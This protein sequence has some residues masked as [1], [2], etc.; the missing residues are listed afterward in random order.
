[1]ND[2]WVQCRE[3]FEVPH[4]MDD[5][6]AI[7]GCDVGGGTYLRLNIHMNPQVEYFRR[8]LLLLLSSGP[9]RVEWWMALVVVVGTLNIILGVVVNLV[10][11]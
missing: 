2:V 1:M 11:V 5:D 8:L 9:F 3:L 7:W 6:G 4:S 10:L